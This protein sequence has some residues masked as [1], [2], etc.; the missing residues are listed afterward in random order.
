M[1]PKRRNDPDQVRG[2]DLS[3]FALRPKGTP[4]HRNFQR[5]YF[6]IVPNDIRLMLRD[7]INGMNDAG[8]EAK[9]S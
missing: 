5:L 2:Y 9:Q 1:L 3:Q 4:A 6:K 8:N 7:H